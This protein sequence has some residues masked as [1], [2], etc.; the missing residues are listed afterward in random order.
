MIIPNAETC[1]FVNYKNI[2]KQAMKTEFKKCSLTRHP[3]TRRTPNG[4]KLE[5]SWN[6]MNK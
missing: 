4:P 1:G 2:K 3:H 6:M 5:N